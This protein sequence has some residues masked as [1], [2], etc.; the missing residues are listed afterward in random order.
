[1]SQQVRDRFNNIETHHQKAY[2]TFLLQLQNMWSSEAPKTEEEEKQKELLEQA[3]ANW[4]FHAQEHPK[5]SEPASLMHATITPKYEQLIHRDVQLFSSGDDDLLAQITGVKG[6]DTPLLYGLLGDDPDPTQNERAV[7]W[8]NL[9]NLYRIAA[10]ICI[11]AKDP[12]IKSLIDTILALSPNIST[13]P[14][15]VQA[16][17][18]RLV[19]ENKDLK[20]MITQMV[21]GKN[22]QNQ[23]GGIISNLKIVLSTL[24]DNQQWNAAAKTTNLV[25]TV[26]STVIPDFKTWST[27]DQDML[28]QAIKD[29]DELLWSAFKNRVTAHQRQTIET[30]CS[31]QRPDLSSMVDKMDSV[32]KNMENGASSDEPPPELVNMAASMMNMSPEELKEMEAEFEDIQTE[33]DLETTD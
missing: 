15:E 6:I 1:M 14:Q 25:P 27:S 2:L 19:K 17:V 10:I 11:Y 16:S 3:Y 29:K 12:Q 24:V 28:E 8:D 22:K 21:S 4:Y 9:L 5:S 31:Q 26:L 20:K 32:F 13:S 30:L 33:L 23:I 7:F 18:M